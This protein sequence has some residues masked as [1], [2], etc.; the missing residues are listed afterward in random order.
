MR[1]LNYRH[2][3]YFWVVAKEGG[4]NRAAIKLGVAAQ[5][6][7]GQL[8]LLERSLGVALLAPAGRGLTLTEAGRTALSYADRIFN[9]GEQMLEALEDGAGETTLRLTVGILDALPKLAAHRLLQP[10]M[11][12]G[13]PVRLSCYEGE[14][15]ELMSDLALHR[16][17]VVLS[18]RPVASSGSLRVFSHPLGEYPVSFYGTPALAERYGKGFPAS[19][20]GA[21]VMLPTRTN[22]LRGKIEQWFEGHELRP[23]VVGEFED[24]ALMDTFGRQG[25]GLFPALT[26]LGPEIAAQ[27]GAQSVG[28]LEGVREQVFAISGERRIRHPCVEAILAGAAR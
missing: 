12:I 14:L 25:M 17:D 18:D 22:A 19:L 11:G 28:E 1:D 23:L 3:H 13:R 21:P 7:S 5:T 24:S 6:I 8:A 27:L 16:L 15:D 26:M 4:V 9:L 10:V 20:A 2:L